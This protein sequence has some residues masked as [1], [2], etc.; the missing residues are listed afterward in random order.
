LDSIDFPK[1]QPA[2]DAAPERAEMGTQNHEGIAGAAAAVDFYASL[3]GGT[4]VP[5]VTHAQDARATRRTALELAFAGLRAH[6]TPQVVRLWEALS[7][8][9]GVRLFGPPPHVAR[10]PTLSFIVKNVASTEVARRLAERGLFVSHGD[11]YAQTVV[12]RLGLQPEGLV[13]VGCAC[14]TSDEEVDRLI[15][16]VR[17]IAT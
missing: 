9:N 16:S 10:T 8:I 7:S 14:Y 15:A 3:A 13:R 2:P 1:L 17:E 12:D 6:S 5:P 11:F 4:G